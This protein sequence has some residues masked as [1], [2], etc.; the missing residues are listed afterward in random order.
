MDMGVGDFARTEPLI[1]VDRIKD[2]YLFGIPLV[3]SLTGQELPERVLR[4]AILK[5]VGDFET[6]VHIPAMPVRIT[7]RFDFERAD[8]M[9]FGMRQLTRFPI[10]KIENLK[11]L[12]PGRNDILM[13]VD[14]GTTQEVD[15]P[16]SWVTLQGDRGIFRIVPNTGSIVNADASFIASSAYRSIILGGLKQWPNMWRVTYIAGFPSDQVPILVNDLIGTFAAI[17]MLGMLGPAIFPVNSHATGID[18]MSQSTST[19]GPQWLAN[20]LQELTAERDRLIAQVKAYYGTDIYFSA[21]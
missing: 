5:S 13:G 16:T 14:G 18:G 20:R 2:E 19:A 1:T 4:Q 7:D 11:A 3:A 15:Y 10:L 8:D 9:Q 12:W 17:R 6:S 21:W